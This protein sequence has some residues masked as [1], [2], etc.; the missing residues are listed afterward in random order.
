MNIFDFDIKKNCPLC[1]HKA[2]IE[3]YSVRKGYEA[4]IH[5]TNCLLNLPSITF[6]TEE[7]AAK[8]VIDQWNNVKE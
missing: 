1:G 6:D 8:S 2:I 5:C 4:T 7:E 3:T